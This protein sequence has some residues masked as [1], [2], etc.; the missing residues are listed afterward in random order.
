M[1]RANL[2][3]LA[4]RNIVITEAD[5]HKEQP[6]VKRLA[7]AYERGE[8]IPPLLVEKFRSVYLLRNGHH[9]LLALKSLGITHVWAW[10]TLVFDWNWAFRP[11]SLMVR[12]SGQWVDYGPFWNTGAYPAH[13][14]VER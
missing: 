2:R 11:G 3:R 9:R 5:E 1:T 10:V 13:E 12:W 4:V 8:P 7:K 6:K 14:E